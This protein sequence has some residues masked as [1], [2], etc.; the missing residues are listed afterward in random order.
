MASSTKGPKQKQ[1]MQPKPG[2]AKVNTN[3]PNQM[4]QSGFLAD[5]Y[6][7]K[8]LGSSVEK[9]VTRFPPEPNGYLHI[10]HSKAIAINFG[11]AK[12]HGGECYLRLDD[13][14]PKG[15]EERYVN[16][17]EEIVRWLG[18]RPLRTTYSSD[19]FD[20]LYD[21]AEDLIRKDRAYVCH[22]T[23]SDIKAQRGLDSATGAKGKARYA[24]S[25]RNRPILE[26]IT[27]FRAMRDGKY[28][29]Q[30][31][32]LRM[33]QDL[34]S[35]N[36]QMW[37]IFAYR[38][39][40]DENCKDGNVTFCKHLRTGDKWKIYPTY[41]FTHCL[42]DSFE[43]ITHSLCTTEFELSRESYEWLC[44]ELGVY[45]PMQREYGR[46]NVSG[47]IL[48][49]RKLIKLVEGEGPTKPNLGKYVKGW[50]DPRLFTL[51]GLRR[52]GVPPGA[53]LSFVNELGVTKAK[54]TIETLR[55]ENAVRT[56]LETTVPRLML[57]LDPIRIIIANLPDD[58][59]EM[60]ELPFSKDPS[61]GSHLVPFTKTVYIDRSDFRETPSA[62]FYRLSPGGAVGLLKVPYPI[63]ATSVEKDPATGLVTTVHAQYTKPE[64]EGT[65][66][67]KPK[68]YIHWVALSRAH[69]SPLRV[70][71]RA[72]NSL[73]NSA[74]P[75]SHPDGFLADINTNSEEVFPNA[76]LDIG[77]KEV[78]SRASWPANPSS[79]DNKVEGVDGPEA[80]RFQGMRVGYFCEDKESTADKLI[81]NRIVTL[82]E[83][84]HKDK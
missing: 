76:L 34:D 44:D 17:I 53:I 83:D 45:K 4:F 1:T 59:V 3:D 35:N 47:T 82:R 2:R 22:C 43:G 75:S 46:L 23:E 36:P 21:L 69:N 40:E 29:A 58:Y 50:D 16:S 18:F 11:F 41:D 19:Y 20:Q 30:Q 38:V 5:V 28:R 51:V 10:G 39:V 15:E 84:S 14:N 62:T 52:R 27:E 26:S 72:F 42:C 74:D 68:A 73:F 49:K 77:F 60:I 64:T 32:A 63:I 71:V 25:H 54:T 66:F 55:F 70:E 81:L 33:K 7:E 57:V 9:I 13:T 78:Q 12:Y 79:S 65:P 48:S 6:K 67:K 24:C 61:H 56:Y 37:D 8:S 80:V 31:A